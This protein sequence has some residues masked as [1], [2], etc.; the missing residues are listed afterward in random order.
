ML[1]FACVGRRRDDGTNTK[2]TIEVN[3]VGYDVLLR[4]ASCH[5]AAYLAQL[6]ALRMAAAAGIAAPVIRNSNPLVTNQ[7]RGQWKARKRSM[8]RYVAMCR[9]AA[10]GMTPVYF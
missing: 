10:A 7:L 5:D 4:R 9:K 8:R 3:G 6:L 2:L 1:Q